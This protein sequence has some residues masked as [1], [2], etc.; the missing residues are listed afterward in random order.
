MS[1]KLKEIKV[2]NSTACRNHRTGQSED[3][4]GLVRTDSVKENDIGDWFNGTEN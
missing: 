2:R 1:W 3:Y 4:S